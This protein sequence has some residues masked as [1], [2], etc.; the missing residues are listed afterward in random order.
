M[1]GNAVAAC[2][3][4]KGKGSFA[5]GRRALC[6]HPAPLEGGGLA[7]PQFPLPQAQAH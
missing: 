3:A 2:Q 4:C 1:E 6:V 5:L 7:V